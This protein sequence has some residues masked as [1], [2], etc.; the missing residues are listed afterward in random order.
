MIYTAQPRRLHH[1]CWSGATLLSIGWLLTQRSL[2]LSSLLTLVVIIVGLICTV[3]TVSNL[4]QRN[5]NNLSTPTSIWMADSFHVVKSNHINID[6]S[7]S[8]QLTP[9]LKIHKHRLSSQFTSPLYPYLLPPT[10]Q[11]SSS[12]TSLSIS[13]STSEASTSQSIQLAANKGK[14]IINICK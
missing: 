14:F 7:T 4:S 9:I 6:S 2:R 11:V 1:Q 8:I 5:T 3:S 12:P 13:E 10:D